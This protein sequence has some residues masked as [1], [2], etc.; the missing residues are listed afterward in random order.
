MS[1]TGAARAWQFLKRNPDYLAKWRN[2]ADAAQV[3]KAAPFP[4]RS[5]TPAD[6]DRDRIRWTRNDCPFRKPH[7]LLFEG[8]TA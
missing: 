5:Q 3:I 2:T 8:Q 1:D 4:V 6:A 7:P